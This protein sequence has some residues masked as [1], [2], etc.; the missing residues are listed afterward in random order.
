M[1]GRRVEQKR[2]RGDLQL[3]SQTFAVL[4]KLAIVHS[5]AAEYRQRL[6]RP[7]AAHALSTARNHDLRSGEATPEPHV[8]GESRTPSARGPLKAQQRYR[9]CHMKPK[10]VQRQNHFSEIKKKV[11][12]KH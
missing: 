11:R 2:F 10:C 6:T 12:R 3:R 1:I 7:H 5:E 8:S 9:V 4:M